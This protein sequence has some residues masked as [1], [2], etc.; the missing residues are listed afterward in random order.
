MAVTLHQVEDACTRE[1]QNSQ[2]EF[3][4]FAKGPNRIFSKEDAIASPNLFPRFAENFPRRFRKRIGEQDLHLSLASSRP[5]EYAEKPRFHDASV[6]NDQYI[7]RLETIGQVGEH[8]IADG[9]A[10]AL[11]DH[12]P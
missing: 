1:L 6:I 10:P 7:S 4:C 12:H 3:A 2:S 8:R 11:D 5:F 9:A